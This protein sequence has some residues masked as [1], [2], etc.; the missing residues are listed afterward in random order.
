ML[1]VVVCTLN[2]ARQ[3]SAVLDCLLAQETDSAYEIV[4][5][6]NNSID[7]TRSIVQQYTEATSGKVRYVFEGQ[8]GVSYGRNAG[9]KA[10]HGEIIAFVDD[11]VIVKPNWLEAIERTY[12]SHPDAWCV[13]GRI[14]LQL[15]LSYPGWFDPTSAFLTG[16]LGRRDRGSDTIKVEYPDVIFGGNFS[17]RKEILS[18]VGPFK[19]YL[20]RVGVKS[21]AGEDD[22][23]CHRVWRA[24][25]AVYYC[26]EAE[27]IHV[28][29]EARLTKRFFRRHI[30]WSARSEA[31]VYPP[32]P[33]RPMWVRVAGAGLAVAKASCRAFAH[34]VRG[35]V[36]RAFQCELE[37]RWRLGVLH[38]TLLGAPSED[39][40]IT[41]AATT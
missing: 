38:Q 21:L 20:G 19:T 13:G 26:G 27:V 15:P 3:I 10:A 41:N 12:R 5:V 22:E 31:I 17:A 34:Y 8:R 16:Y 40:R 7:G 18:R 28:V 33:R 29:P 24:G 39:E 11:G 25:G 4:V 37:I 9:I 2:R 32:D 30:Y 6:D 35:D 14:T 1:S 23:M 36:P